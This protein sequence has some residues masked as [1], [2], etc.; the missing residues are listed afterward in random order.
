MIAQ[1]K[2]NPDLKVKVLS[3]S[4]K[5]F[6]GKIINDT[7]VWKKDQICKSFLISNFYIISEMEDYLDTKEKFSQLINNL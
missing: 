3:Y 5:T 6:S 2:T 7:D 4:A 1:F